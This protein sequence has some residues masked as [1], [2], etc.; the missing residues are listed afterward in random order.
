MT[1][2]FIAKGDTGALLASSESANYEFAQRMTSG[3]TV[4]NVT[5]YGFSYV[6]FPM[7]FIEVPVGG[8]AGIL[9]FTSTTV[10]IIA[11][12]VYPVN[13]FKRVESA[14]GFG[15]AAFD[16]AGA[17]TFKANASILNV[18]AAGAM[19]IGGSFTGNGSMV[20]FPALAS[21][22]LYSYT[23]ALVYYTYY[24]WAT[25]D[26]IYVCNT[27]YSLVPVQTCTYDY[28][29]GY[30]CV[31]TGYDY[32]PTTTCGYQSVIT[33]YMTDVYANVRTTT[34]AVQRS[35]ARRTGA[36]TYVQDWVTHTSGYYKDVID[37]QYYTS[38]F[39]LFAPSG[40]TPP[41][42][43]Y[44]SGSP[45]TGADSVYTKDNT[46]PYSNGQTKSISATILTG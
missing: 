28:T 25:V 36:N 44:M 8:K 34:W 19:G 43:G 13:V 26:M 1:F 3:S 20:S 17:L 10:R 2:G 21:Q 24:G 42:I 38:S 41:L 33:N 7:F 46:F 5:T 39:S 32:V 9:D 11:D 40:Y 12:G 6:D 27:T 16:A 14:S 29:F 37:W 35:V 18:Q 45:Y 15:I 31:T 23:D 30:I 4:G 22:T